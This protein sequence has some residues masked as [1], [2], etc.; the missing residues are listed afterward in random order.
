M[1]LE[2]VPPELKRKLPDI[3]LNNKAHR[4][5]FM[6]TMRYFAAMH[7][8]ASGSKAAGSPHAAG[9]SEESLLR[10]YEGASLVDWHDML[11]YLYTMQVNHQRS[12]TLPPT[13]TPIHHPM[14]AQRKRSGRSTWRP[15][16]A[17]TSATRARGRAWW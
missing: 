11:D 14:H 1:G 16:P 17:L 10:M 4:E 6:N 5:S 12:L 9:M 3:D 2:K 8:G 13:S 7:G 15:A